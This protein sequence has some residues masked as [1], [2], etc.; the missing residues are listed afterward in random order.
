MRHS[1]NNCP[2]VLGAAALE[3]ITT[4]AD[5]RPEYACRAGVSVSAGPAPPDIRRPL[6][7]LPK[8]REL[9]NKDDGIYYRSRIH[10]LMGPE[11]IVTGWWDNHG[12]HRDYYVGTD[13]IAGRVWIYHDLTTRQK[14]YLHGLFG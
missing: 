11:R 8:P 4:H 1:L 10:S 6:W 2:P 9:L 14:W 7:L 3:S 5:H 12:I 13:D